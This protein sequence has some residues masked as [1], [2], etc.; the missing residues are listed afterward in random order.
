MILLLDNHDSFT[1]NLVE[2][3][4]SIGKGNVKIIPPEQLNTRELGGFDRVIL[5]PGP[6]LPGEQPVMSGLL[7]A[8]SPKVPVLGVCLGMQS[9]AE[10]YGGKLFNLPEVVHGQ[11]RELRISR[12][13]HPLFE[14][15][16]DGAPV[17]LYHSWAVDPASLPSCL[18]VI[19]TDA[20]GTVMAIA[21]KSLP[22]CGV[23]FHPESFM[24][25]SGAR[26]MENWLKK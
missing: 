17:G 13:V 20:G 23:Q 4:R 2:L 24:T 7:G 3:L 16:A 6:G 9:I 19:A 12:P 22:V 21:H 1:W 15:I 11:T 25:P 10:F 18:G 14:G 26:M 5:S 8:I